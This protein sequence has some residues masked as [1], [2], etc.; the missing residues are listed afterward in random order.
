MFF[1]VIRRE[2]E[3]LYLN[4]NRLAFIRVTPRRS[5]RVE[6]IAVFANDLPLSLGLFDTEEDARRFVMEIF[7]ERS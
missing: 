5:G 1:T 3:T 6:V 7:G 4:V 2:S